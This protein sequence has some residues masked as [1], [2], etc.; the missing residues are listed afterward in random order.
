M[1]EITQTKQTLKQIF[2]AV[3]LHFPNQTLLEIKVLPHVLLLKFKEAARFFSKQ[4]A[5]TLAR[6]PL[7]TLTKIG[8]NTVYKEVPQPKSI[9]Q[10]EDSLLSAEL[11]S[12][13]LNRIQR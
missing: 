2:K 4:V 8:V 9:K 3:A 13:L 12:A 6:L 5:A 7:S 11:R 1:Y 10:A